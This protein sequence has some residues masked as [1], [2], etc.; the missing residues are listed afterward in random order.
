MVNWEKHNSDSDMRREELKRIIENS[1]DKLSVEELEALYYD[2][3]TKG[4]I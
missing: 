2:M 1:L 3:L 4:Y